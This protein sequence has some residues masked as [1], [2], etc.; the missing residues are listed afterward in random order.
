MRRRACQQP[1]PAG[2]R[3]GLPVLGRP[4]VR[5]GPHGAAQLEAP[6]RGGRRG[7]QKVRQPIG[8]QGRDQVTRKL[9][10]NKYIFFNNKV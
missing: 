2:V 10:R 6:Q 5:L 4:R 3:E 7:R 1:A 8:G 9:F